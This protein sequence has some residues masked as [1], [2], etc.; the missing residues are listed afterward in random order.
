MFIYLAYKGLSNYVRNRHDSVFLVGFISYLVLG[1]GSFC[2][3]ATLTCVY[4]PFH[5]CPLWKVYTCLTIFPDPMQLLDELAMIYTSS[6]LFYAVFSHGRSTLMAW[7]IGLSVASLAVFITGYYHYLK[8]PIFHQNAFAALTAAVCFRSMY[9]MEKALRPS[10]RP[11]PDLSSMDEKSRRALKEQDRRDLQTLTM[12][13]K[14]VGCGLGAVGLGFL[15]WNLDTVFCSTLRRWRVA[16]G[17][18]WG[19]F[20]EGH[21]WW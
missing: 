7:A 21:G 13:W 11:R 19:I 2:F 14:L 8:N 1:V 9:A 5:G 3:H 17:L 10:R 16:V 6:I 4:K 15:L 18:P 12:M 20:L